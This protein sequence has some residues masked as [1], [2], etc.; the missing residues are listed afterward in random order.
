[1]TVDE[2]VLAATMGISFGIALKLLSELFFFCIR[3]IISWL[4]LKF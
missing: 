3:K 4:Q 1:M 2:M